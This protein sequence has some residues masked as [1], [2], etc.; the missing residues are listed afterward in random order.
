M[1]MY[2]LLKI[3]MHFI[4]FMHKKLKAYVFCYYTLY[5]TVNDHSVMQSDGN[6]WNSD[7]FREATILELVI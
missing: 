5:N 1:L 2:L 6:S 7:T 4:Q 3:R